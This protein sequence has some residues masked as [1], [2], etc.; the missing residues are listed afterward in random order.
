MKFKLR[1]SLFPFCGIAF[2]T[3]KGPTMNAQVVRAFQC[4]LKWEISIGLSLC[5]IKNFDYLFFIEICTKIFLQ[6]NKPQINL[7]TSAIILTQPT[8]KTLTITTAARKNF[9]FSCKSSSGYREKEIHEKKFL[10]SNI[11]YQNR[12]LIHQ[13][14]HPKNFPKSKLFLCAFG[15]NS[16][17]NADVRLLTS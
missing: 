1:C 12:M 11:Q 7:L 9:C 2:R 16:L 13:E 6:F 3:S 4:R 14:N 10:Y 8:T 5:C 17:F 15:L